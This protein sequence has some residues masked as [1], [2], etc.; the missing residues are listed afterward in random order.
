MASNLHSSLD[1]SQL[2]NPKGFADAANNTYLTKN[3]GGSL[4]WAGNKTRHYISTGGY[5]SGSGS[6]GTCY[7][8]QFSADYHNINVE[9]DPE[10]ATNNSV[11]VGMKWAHM[12]SEFICCNSGTITKWVCMH[13]GSASADWDL[14]LYKLSVTSGTGA[15]VNPVK[16]GETLNLTN[17][18]SGNKFVTKVEMGLTGTLTFADGDVLIQVLKKQTA[19]T[20]TIWWNGTLELTF[21]Y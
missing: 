1:D 2:H 20:K 6:V 3:S 12:H 5:H 18:S 15:N 14:E 19:G 21:D 10:D 17:H 4:V 16:L 8:K 13:G 11:N 7:A 9:V